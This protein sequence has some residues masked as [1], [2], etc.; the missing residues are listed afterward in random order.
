MV[1]VTH[2][3]AGRRVRRPRGHRPRRP[4]HAP[5]PIP[6]RDPARAAP[7]RSPV[8]GR[9]LAALGAHRRCGRDR[10]GAAAHHPRRAATPSDP[11][12][13]VRVARDRLLRCSR[14]AVDGGVDRGPALVVSSG[15]TPTR[16]RRSAAS[17]SPPPARTSPVPPACPR[18]PARGSTTPRPRWSICSA[19]T[20]AAQLAD[21]YPGR[22]R[23]HH[24]RRRAARAGHPDRRVGR[25]SAESRERRRPTV[26]RSAPR[27]RADCTGEC[28][29]ARHRRQRHRPDL[30]GRRR[31]AAVPRAHL[32]RRRHPALRR[33]TRAALRRH[34]AGGATPRQVA[35]IV[36]RRVDRSPPC[37]ASLVGFGLFYRRPARPSPT[38]RS[39][40]RRSSSATSR[41]VHDRLVAVGLGI[42][43]GAAIAARLALRRV[44]VSPLGVSRRVTPRPPRPLRI[45]PLAGRPAWMVYLAYGSDITRPAATSRPTPTC[46]ACSP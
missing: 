24:R 27:R 22:A 14:H 12:R 9:S 11:E 10:R 39:P 34:A 44:T 21:R 42:P 46:W 8:A 19:T 6:V 41:L 43:I 25:R 7:R 33:P 38:S 15:V 30:H 17:T 20:P 1:L 18:S 26:S 29:P 37:S 3:A 36:D 4:V 45:L 28:A 5:A 35:R 31:R 40:A 2:D 23:R 13:A 32:H 16:E